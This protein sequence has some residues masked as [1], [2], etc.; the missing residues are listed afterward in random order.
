MRTLPGP[1][2]L[3]AAFFLLALSVFA[4]T[5]PDVDARTSADVTIEAPAAVETPSTTTADPVA[6]TI[7]VDDVAPAFLDVSAPSIDSID[8]MDDLVDLGNFVSLGAS[9][10]LPVDG[11]PVDHVAAPTFEHVQ[12]RAGPYRS[13]VDVRRSAAV[14]RPRVVARLRLS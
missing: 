6:T 14:P 1:A 2:P 3:F 8:L 11:L 12:H 5:L 4:A 10:G 9:Y 7:A 13:P